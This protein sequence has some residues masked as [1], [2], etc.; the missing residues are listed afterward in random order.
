MRFHSAV[1]VW[2]LAVLACGTGQQAKSPSLEINSTDIDVGKV[3]QGET[4]KHVFSFTNRGP[5]TLE[6]LNVGHS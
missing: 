6:I 3:T 5:G 2:V 4:I 1:L